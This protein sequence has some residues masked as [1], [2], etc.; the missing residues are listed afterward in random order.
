MIDR[1]AQLLLASSAEILLLI[2]A[3]S[4]SI[5]DAND[6]A[7]IELGY[8]SEQLIGK[9]V[10]DLE[11]ALQD[12]FYW[13][14]VAA[15][16]YRELNA[17]DGL[18]ACADGSLMPVTKS[19]R[20]ADAGDQPL[21]VMRALDARGSV[22]VAEELEANTSLLRS[23]FES[24]A[25]GLL[26]LE[27]DGSIMNFSRRFAELWKLDVGGERDDVRILRSMVRSCQ[28]GA[29]GNSPWRSLLGLD[30]GEVETEVALRD[31]RTFRVRAR[32]LLMQ[33]SVHGRVLTCSDIT[34]RIT[35]ERELAAARD[36]AAASE[37]A[38]ASFLAMMSHEI[39]TPMSGILGMTE[40]ACEAATDPEQRRFI[41]MAHSSAEGLLTIINDL[42][43][44]SKIEAGK[45]VI[46]R[47][48]VDVAALLDTTL[49]PLRWQAQQKGLALELA[50]PA[51]SPPMVMGDPTRV[52]QI[53]INLVGNALK[54]TTEGGITVRLENLADGD[55]QTRMR[56]SVR[57]TG[58]GIPAE[59]Q[60]AIFEAFSQSDA[61]TSRRFGGTGLGL[62]ICARLTELMHGEI[63][64]DSVPGDGSTFS[65]ELPFELASKDQ[66][67]AAEAEAAPPPSRPLRILVA[68]DTEVNQVYLKHT[69]ERAGHG[70]RIVGNGQL[71][72][73]AAGEAQFDAILMDVQMPVLDGFAATEALR[74]S[75][76]ETPIIGLTAHAM[77]D[78]HALCLS[79]GMSDY[80]PKPVRAVALL[81]M[82]ARIGEEAASAAL[83][84]LAEAQSPQG[85]EPPAPTRDS[86][87]PDLERRQAIANLAGDECLWRDMVRM[88]W[89]QFDADYPLI[90]A[91]L[92]DGDLVIAREAAHRLKSSFAVV[93]ALRAAD[94]C[95]RIERHARAERLE[96]ARQAFA[97]LERSIEALRCALAP[98]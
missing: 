44:F 32:P 97:E 95:A 69:L 4:R 9:P 86:A 71:A 96:E 66:I 34:D 21:L 18:L 17:V 16:S 78:V 5:V 72:V 1:H 29:P 56:I 65:F 87:I 80:L 43:D 28:L 61:Q 59:R 68:E 35:Y 55:G 25:E 83:D 46:E 62:T 84:T 67:A 92:A 12:A 76:L 45:F 52:R 77:G 39:R 37:R 47:I 94:I 14:D 42:L 13:E 73:D 91:G 10:M 48:P 2:D 30:E 27:L 24:T 22:A 63:G 82:L 75:G 23:I 6:H 70:V 51:E 38:K 7:L 57:D 54:F 74:E 3:G 20:L 50:L 49:E 88:L 90:E 58:I 98:G 36:A 89:E 53:L 64:V 31:G 41:E 40:L 93:G 15:G 81:E 79:H 85:S 26:V 19:V 33:D 60:G 11:C 8:T